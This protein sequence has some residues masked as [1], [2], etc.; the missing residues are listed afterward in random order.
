MVFSKA[1][2][3][4]MLVTA[5]DRLTAAD[6]LQVLTFIVGDESTDLVGHAVVAVP[7]CWDHRPG[8]EPGWRG[9]WLQNI[10]AAMIDWPAAP[11]RRHLTT[12]V[13]RTATT[14]GLQQRVREELARHG[15]DF[16]RWRVEPGPVSRR[17][18]P[19][20][21]DL[22]RAEVARRYVELQG[23]KEK[24]AR[25]KV[26]LAVEMNLSVNTVNSLLFQARKRGLLTSAGPGRAGGGLTERA[27]QILDAAS[28]PSDR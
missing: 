16:W 4:R 11:E 14:T 17:S 2:E 13:V 22:R 27:R 5:A 9:E 23:M 19:Q 20:A 6:W 25:P 15:Y 21:G 8:Y 10:G 1:V 26:A 28:E 12:A 24:A 3:G 18:G 7:S